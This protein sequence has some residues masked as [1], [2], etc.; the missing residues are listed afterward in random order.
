MDIKIIGKKE[1][2][3]MLTAY[4]YP[5]AK[6]LEQAGI[7]II[8][9]GD[10]GAMVALGYPDTKSITMDEMLMLTRAVARGA[11]DT[12]ILGDMPIDSDNTPEE[13]LKNAKLFLEAGAHGVKIEGYKP[14]VIKILLENNI[15]VQ[16]HLGLLPQTADDYKVQGKDKAQ[17]EQ[18]LE[19]AVELDKLGIFSLVLECIPKDLAAEITKKV[20]T[21]TIGIGAGPDCDGQVLVLHDMLGFY[22]KKL[23]FVKQYVNL[24]HMIGN[25][26]K[27]Y[28]KDVE[29]GNFPK[30]EHSFR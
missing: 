18:I 2:I 22:D 25:A 11:K 20:K 26:V 19:E 28:I 17:A 13:A 5:T 29:E 15:P 7:D 12:L 14:D 1:K 16:G 10:S 4:D 24:N 21:K 8:L 3:T 27:Q 9:V 30:E 6:L 23:K